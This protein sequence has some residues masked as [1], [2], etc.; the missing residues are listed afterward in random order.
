MAIL[1]DMTS[2]KAQANR[3]G[4]SPVIEWG[5]RA[6]YV[7]SGIVHLLIAWIAA[8]LAVGGSRQ[9]ADQSGAF[10]ALASTGWGTVLMV[11]MAVG[12]ALLAIWQVTEAIRAS[13]W[14][15]RVKPI[16]KALAYL[17]LAS[18][19]VTLLVTHKADS[20]EQ[21]QDTTRTALSMPGGPVLVVLAGLVVVGVGGYHVYKGVTKKFHEDLVEHPGRAA[22]VMG[23]LG[24]AAKGIALLIAGGLLAWAGITGDTEQARGLDGAFKA[25]LEVSFGR[26]LVVAVAVGLACFAIYCLIRARF[27]RV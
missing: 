9:D 16:G 19:A 12:L 1:L 4:E 17:M 22:E 2:V 23:T 13:E 14:S 10:Q 8:S 21:A 7:A 18:P 6:G 26:V 15:K 25:L 27:A 3:V 5:A 24:Y 20:G 11:A